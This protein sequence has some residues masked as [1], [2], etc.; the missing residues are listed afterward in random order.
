VER[1]EDPVVSEGARLTGSVVREGGAGEAL[2]LGDLAG[3]QGDGDL[4]DAV[5]QNG[6]NGGRLH[7]LSS[8]EES[9]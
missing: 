3:S 8:S 4:E 5:G 2:A 6:G 1:K 9:V 7:V